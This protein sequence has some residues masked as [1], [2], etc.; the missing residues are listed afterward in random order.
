[1]KHHKFSQRS[2][3]RL[4]ACH[5]DLQKVAHRALELSKHDFGITEGLRTIERQKELFESGAS[6]TMNSRHLENENGVSEALDIGVYIE[7]GL[8]WE[9]GYYRQVAQA[10]F[11]AA[12]E[13]G[14]PI[15]WGG[16]WRTFVDG[17]HFQ[18]KRG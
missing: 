2:L 5:K 4:S 7:S 12:I 18:L 6:T 11:D 16:L 9:I 15:E 17:P 1:M 14:I 10:F 13:L 3:E 8:T